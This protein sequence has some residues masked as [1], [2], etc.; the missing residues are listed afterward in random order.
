M[1]KKYFTQDEV[2]LAIRKFVAEAGSQAEAARR[3][4]MSWRYLN[5]LLLGRTTLSKTIAEK[6]GFHKEDALFTKDKE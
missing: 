4:N 2:M 6:F 3:V 1:K 5:N